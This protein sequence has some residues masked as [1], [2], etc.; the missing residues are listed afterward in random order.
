M[1]LY[2]EPV[3]LEFVENADIS[4]Q[5]NETQELMNEVRAIA[6]IAQRLTSEFRSELEASQIQEFPF[7][8]WK[9]LHY[10]CTIESEFFEI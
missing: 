3:F 1:S 8:S 10:Y 5:T 4:N 6:S 7:L 9:E 2:N